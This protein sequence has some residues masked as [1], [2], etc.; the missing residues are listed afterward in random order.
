MKKWRY[1]HVKTGI[2]LDGGGTSANTDLIKMKL[3]GHYIM[4]HRESAGQ[5]V[6]AEKAYEELAHSCH[7]IYEISCAAETKCR[8]LQ[9]AHDSLQQEHTKLKVQYEALQARYEKCSRLCNQLMAHS[10]ELET[11]NTELRAE[12][13]R[14]EEELYD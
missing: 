8:A 12:R 2:S 10:I 4:V 1:T 14:L 6:R 7:Q 3:C 13:D 9:A 11:Q 5:V